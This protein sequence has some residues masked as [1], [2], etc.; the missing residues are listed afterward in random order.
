MDRLTALNV[1]RH[2]V[3]LQSFAAASRQLNLSAAA[4]SKNIRELEEH[5]G[6]LLLNRTTRRL[7]KTEAGAQYYQHV[8]RILDDLAESEA[9][10]AASR[11]DP[12][13]MLRV[14]APMT[15]GLTSLSALIPKFLQ[16]YPGVTID[17]HL[18]SRKVNIVE[19]G[20]DLAIRVS[21]HLVDSSL[22]AR[23]LMKMESVVCGSPGYFARFGAPQIPDDLQH[24]ECI[25]FSLSGH[26]NEWTFH[27]DGERAV[28]SIDGRYKVTSS[29]AVRDA[30]VADGGLS[31]L[32]RLYVKEELATGRLVTV[33]DGWKANETTVYA[34]Y[35]SRRYV[36]SKVRAF[37]DFIAIELA[38]TGVEI[39]EH[40]D[41]AH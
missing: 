41:D 36:P 3:E 6:A 12:T 25:Q 24:H 21:D 27:R 20:F 11:H 22:I 1:F 38:G 23:K 34:V 35:P 16:Q 7:S 37:I 33:L 30:L 18:D 39:T 29:L 10:I 19:E 8:V 26:V 14:T 4:V 32:P 5:L 2:V 17:L 15:L 31:L 28:V 9:S 13:G 40:L